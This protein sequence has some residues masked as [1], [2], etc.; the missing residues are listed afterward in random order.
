[1]DTPGVQLQDI[2]PQ[3]NGL[4]PS[5]HQ[6][7]SQA[8]RPKTL[9]FGG[10]DGQRD[11]DPEYAVKG[12]NLEMCLWEARRYPE[13]VAAVFLDEMG[14]TRWPDP[15]ADWAGAAPGPTARRPTTGCGGWPAA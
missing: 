1:M 13:D 10:C 7:P 14:Y 9:H 15:A 6:K 8:D 5:E 11:P 4:Q 12:A 3:R 2:W